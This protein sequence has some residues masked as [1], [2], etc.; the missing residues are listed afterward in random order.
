MSTD[1]YPFIVLLPRKEK[2]ELAQERKIANEYA[3]VSRDLPTTRDFQIIARACTTLADLISLI[4]FDY[5]KETSR[6]LAVDRYSFP[7]SSSLL[8]AHCFWHLGS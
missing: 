8:F 1:T 2:K 4:L 7:S 3:K 6:K 5:E